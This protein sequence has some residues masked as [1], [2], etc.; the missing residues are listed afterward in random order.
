MPLL[1]QATSALDSLTERL[2]QDSLARIR[3]RCTQV[4]RCLS[5]AAHACRQARRFAG[6]PVCVAL[7][8]PRPSAGLP[9]CLQIIVAHRLSTIADADRIVVLDKGLVRR[10]RGWDTAGAACSSARLY[11][12]AHEHAVC[13]LPA[14][15]VAEQG[16]HA[17][18]VEAGGLYFSMWAR[19]QDAMMG[20]GGALSRSGS[21]RAA[22]ASAGSDDADAA[23]DDA[24]LQR[25]YRAGTQQQLE[26]QVGGGNADEGEDD[27]GTGTDWAAHQRR[28]AHLG[29]SSSVLPSR[30]PSRR[31]SFS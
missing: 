13:A 15:Q 2:I 22:A 18:L 28:A 23:I 9:L 14:V 1:P 30:D 21:E 25:Q 5:P 10:R 11:A 12:C 20:G 31:N 8:P 24:S 3:G 17:Q 27:E 6:V 4:R 16:T 29:T 26:Q 19:Q 7:S